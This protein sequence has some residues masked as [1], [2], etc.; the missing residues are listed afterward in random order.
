MC[1][2]GSTRTEVR[3]HRLRHIASTM[4]KQGRLSLKSCK[5]WEKIPPKESALAATEQKEK[6]WADEDPQLE[7]GKLQTETSPQNWKVE[8]G[9]AQKLP[10]FVCDSVHQDAVR[11]PSKNTHQKEKDPA[12]Y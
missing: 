9:S 11:S 3:S 10:D 5:R 1:I 12:R 7:L 4:R 8:N 6:I 2:D